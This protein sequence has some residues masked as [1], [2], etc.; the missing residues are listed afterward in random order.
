MS[1]NTFGAVSTNADLQAWREA[2]RRP[3]LGYQIGQTPQSWRISDRRPFSSSQVQRIG[4]SIDLDTITDDVLADFW[5]LTPQDS[6]LQQFFVQANSTTPLTGSLSFTLR[7]AVDG[8]FTALS[9][10]FTLTELPQEPA[11][12]RANKPWSQRGGVYLSVVGK[13]QSVQLY[14][15]VEHMTSE[16][17]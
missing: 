2:R 9:E 16:I 6:S 17:I 10:T 5:I 3:V 15:T 7:E 4:Q 12:F 8:K 14:A 1:W 11:A 13:Q